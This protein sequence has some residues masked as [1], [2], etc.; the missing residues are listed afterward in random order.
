IGALTGETG[1]FSRTKPA[2]RLPGDAMMAALRTPAGAV[3][4]PI[5]TPQGVYVLKVLERVAP[6]LKDLATER[7]QLSRTVLQQKQGEAWQSWMIGARQNA[8]IE[9]SPRLTSRRG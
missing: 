2:E 1:R 7:D 4:E 9:V 3:T 5:R 8:K 6:D